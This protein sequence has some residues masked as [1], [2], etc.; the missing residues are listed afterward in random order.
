[1]DVASDRAVSLYVVIRPIIL[2]TFD[3]LD[4]LIAIAKTTDHN[5]PKARAA[6]KAVMESVEAWENE[7]HQEKCPKATMEQTPK[8]AVGS[9]AEHPAWLKNVHDLVCDEMKQ[10]GEFGDGKSGDLEEKN[11]SLGK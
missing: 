7:T 9:S 4:A 11:K 1:M 5:D 8:C 2:E 10:R 3:R 6:V